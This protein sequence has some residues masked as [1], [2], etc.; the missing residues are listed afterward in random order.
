MRTS[1]LTYQDLLELFP[2][3]TTRR[4]ELIGGELIVPPAPTFR[5]QHVV[6]GIAAALVAHEKTNG[7]LTATGPDVYLTERDVVQPDVC[8]LLP[9]NESRV[10]GGIVRGP[11]D[12]AVEVSSPSTRRNDLAR[13]LVLYARHG[14][15][16]YWFVDLEAD[17]IEIRNLEGD[18]Y[19]EPEI[20]GRGDAL[21]SRLDGFAASV[22]E[23]LD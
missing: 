1:G 17:R 23:L 14:V 2:E 12:L 20:F 3:E 7:G 18:A 21:R 5:H 16:E 6:A 8:F 13:K 4:I 15:R 11:V 19:R 22:D 10:E 9:G